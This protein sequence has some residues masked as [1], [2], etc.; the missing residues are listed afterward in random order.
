MEDK[1]PLWMLSQLSSWKRWWWQAQDAGS[2]EQ[3]EARFEIHFAWLAAA[4][5]MHQGYGE[6]DGALEYKGWEGNEIDSSDMG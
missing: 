1:R 4:L 5:G 2:A 6:E 3:G